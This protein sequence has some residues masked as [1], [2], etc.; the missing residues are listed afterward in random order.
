MIR[1]GRLFGVLAL[2]VALALP[3]AAQTVGEGDRAAIE[4]L[5]DGQIAAFRRD[6]GAA[7]YAMAAPAI[8]TIFPTVEQF[9][10]MVRS[11]YSPVYRP[12]SVVF[13]PLVE[14]AQGPVQK[15]FLTGPDGLAYV[16]AYSLERQADG[17]WKI[18]G[19]VLLRDDRPSI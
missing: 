11:G 10:S 13:G 12:Q 7:A 6:D 5:I 2:A 16:A 14:T 18:S 3:A 9:M 8:Q 19:C 4:A 17:S 15:V 1:L